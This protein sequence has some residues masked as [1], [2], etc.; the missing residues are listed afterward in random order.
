MR[1]T[2]RW[3]FEFQGQ[4]AVE[5]PEDLKPYLAMAGSDLH[6]GW[7]GG[8]AELY[9]SQGAVELKKK[10]DFKRRDQGFSRNRAIRNNRQRIVKVWDAKKKRLMR[11][12]PDVVDYR[13]DTIIDLKN[14]FMKAPP[15][16]GGRFITVEE[17]GEVIPGEGLPPGFDLPEGHQDAWGELKQGVEAKLSRQYQSQFSRYHRAY[18]EA[19]GREPHL[20]IYVVLFCKTRDAVPAPHENI[21]KLGA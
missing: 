10:K 21:P 12:M 13:H 3:D 17:V 15:D 14:H 2:F 6:Q 4:F 9:L 1:L 16:P 8:L 20:N 7:Y 18:Q 19:T 11:A 5:V